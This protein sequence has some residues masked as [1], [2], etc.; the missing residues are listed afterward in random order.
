M[1]ETLYKIPLI[2]AFTSE[3]ECPFCVI[4][5][6][7]ENKALDFVVGSDSYMQSDIREATDK[8]G[9]CRD[10]LKKMYLYGNAQGN[11]LILNTHY[12][13]L[14]AE[15]K[16]EFTKYKP[17]KAS[18]KEKLPFGNN[19]YSFD[20]PQDPIAIFCR[21]KDINCYVCDYIKNTYDRYFDTFFFLYK[22]EP[23]F[24]DMVKNCKGFCLHHLGHLFESARTSLSEKEILALSE[25]IFPIIERNFMR[26]NEDVSWFCDKFDYR[27][28]DA[29]WKN[30]RDAVQRGMQKLRGGFPDDPAYV[31]KK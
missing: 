28:K 18:L 11:A 20:A 27:N 2:D 3:D 29:D 8:T 22:K 23:D 6:D 21:K 4:E 12:K 9:F 15:L 14:L 26:V 24:K 16:N 31:Q 5:R 7:L 17:A 1:K 10:H 30:S 19:G 25:L 13:K